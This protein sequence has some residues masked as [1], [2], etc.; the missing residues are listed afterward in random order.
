MEKTWEISANQSGKLGDNTGEIWE[1]PT[2]NG[3]NMGK[4][5]AN[6]TTY[7]NGKKEKCNRN[8]ESYGVGDLIVHFAFG[9]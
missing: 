7:I 9:L 3:E 6:P 1:H 5:C 2:T 8:G 4:I